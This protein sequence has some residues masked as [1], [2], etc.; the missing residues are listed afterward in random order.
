MGLWLRPV[1]GYVLCLRD[2]EFF[3]QKEFISVKPKI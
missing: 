1:E 3:D 2:K